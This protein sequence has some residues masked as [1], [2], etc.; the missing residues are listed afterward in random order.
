[1]RHLLK[2]GSYVF[3]RVARNEQYLVHDYPFTSLIEGLHPFPIQLVQFLSY[4]YRRQNV[5]TPILRDDALPRASLLCYFRDPRQRPKRTTTNDP[6]RGLLLPDKHDDEEKD[7]KFRIM[8]DNLDDEDEEEREDASWGVEDILTGAIYALIMLLMVLNIDLLT[9]RFGVTV[10]DR[11]GMTSAHGSDLAEVNFCRESSTSIEQ[12]QQI[13]RYIPT[14]S[15]DYCTTE[16][17]ALSATAFEHAKLNA[18]DAIIV[19][20]TKM[21]RPEEIT[22][23]KFLSGTTE[24]KAEVLDMAEDDAEKGK[25]RQPVGNSMHAGF[26][27]PWRRAV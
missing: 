9:S 8:D 26:G 14:E 5:R 17:L 18:D 7:T 12:D 11:A 1:M 10:W 15:H 25:L 19:D 13:W 16:I 3:Q 23:G 4:R 21:P 20:V 6:K 27:G 22:G 2:D 24:E